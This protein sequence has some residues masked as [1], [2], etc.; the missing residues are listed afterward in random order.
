M[1]GVELVDVAA[2]D[3]GA[4][5]DRW[6]KRRYPA[7][8]QGRLQKLLRTGQI[9]VDGG[10]AKANQIIEAG[11]T[12]RIPPLDAGN[13]GQ[14]PRQTRGEKAAKVSP[15]DTRFMA[16]LVVHDDPDFVVLNKPSGLAVQGGSKTTRHVDALAPALM[17]P[18]DTEPPRLA[19]RLD[20]DTSGVLVLGRTP[21]ATAA[22]ARAF[23]SHR[24]VKTYWAITI[25]APVPAEG[26]VKG[27]MRK[28]HK[29]VRGEGREIMVAAR[30]GED[31][32]VH[33][34][35]QYAVIAKAGARAAWVALR[36]ETGRTHQLRLH[37]SL[38]GTAIL[39][40]G[41]YTCHREA[42]QGLPNRLHLHA[43]SITLPHPTTGEDIT[44]TAPAPPHMRDAFDALGF[45]VNDYPK[46][47]PFAWS[48][49]G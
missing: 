4:R 28:G 26:E 31:D 8:T 13:P 37:M 42:P 35:T 12:I 22:L 49:K 44:L 48:T 33:A 34:R 30:H 27:F 24:V 29:S 6:F 36:P 32:A 25:G 21:A 11:Q 14:A 17:R 20:R 3:A 10:R 43:A 1:S 16:D 15:K 18:G 40:D 38:L 47:D 23:Q 7:L 39:G 41:K 45:N 2:G 19:H 5:L 46:T 9:R